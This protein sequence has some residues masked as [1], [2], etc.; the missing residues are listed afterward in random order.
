MQQVVGTPRNKRQHNVCATTIS[1][2]AGLPVAKQWIMLVK[3]LLCAAEV[4]ST[5]CALLP[6]VL[7]ASL[8]S[9]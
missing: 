7:P 6:P 8:R 4:Q 3:S 5:E 9:I 2:L 1:L